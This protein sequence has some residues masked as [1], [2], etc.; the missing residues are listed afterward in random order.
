MR[1]SLR[2]LS[3]VC[4]LPLTAC[5]S[6]EPEPEPVGDPPVAEFV[7]PTR[8][9]LPEFRVG[10]VGDGNA[11]SVAA[12]IRDGSFEWPSTGNDANGVTWF[13]LDT[14]ENGNIG[15]FSSSA[16]YAV[17]RL[18]DQPDI[19]DRM[20]A[21]SS[22]TSATYIGSTMQ[23]GYFYGDGRARIP[24]IPKEDNSLVVLRARR[25]RDVVGQLYSTTDELWMNTGDL[26]AP[27][28]IVGETGEHW[29][30]VPV[31]NL[32]RRYLPGIRCDV[33]DN[34]FFEASSTTFPSLGPAT[35]T[36]L[37][38]LLRPKTAPADTETPYTA[39]LRVVA[40]GLDFSYERDVDI[41]V[42][43]PTTG[44]WV[45]FKT[46]V[47]G[48]IQRYGVLRPS[49]YDPTRTDYALVLS[50]HGAGVQ[51]RGQA[52]AYSAK[53]WAF[54]IAP[55]NRHEFGFDWEEW[56]RFN[57][58]AAM[59]DAASLFATD[60]TKQYLTGHSMGGHGTWHVGVTTPGR[61]ATV[62]PSAGWESFYTYSSG[63]GSSPPGGAIGRA[64]A[65]SVTLDYIDNL[66][67]RGAFV[68]HGT[69]DDNV[70]WS[71]GQNMYDAVSEVTDDAHFH[72][73]EGAGHWWDA[74]GDEPG[75]DCVDWEPMFEWMD[76]HE[77]D[78]FETDFVFRSPSP[79]YQ[80]V[81]SFVT[82]SSAESMYSDV[83]V[84]SF[85]ADDDSLTILTDNVRTL[86]LDGDALTDLGITEV[87]IDGGLVTVVPGPITNGPS[88]G[89]QKDVYG[90][91]NQVYRAPFC[92]VYAEGGLWAEYTSFLTT[93]WATLGN[94][95]ACAVP[96][97]AL[98][99]ELR[100][101]YQLIYVGID[102]DEL[103]EP[104]GFNWNGDEIDIGPVD[105]DSSA[106]VMVFDDGGK[107]G[108][109]LTATDDAQ[110]ALFNA[111]PFSSRSGMPDWT[112][113]SETGIRNSGMF[114]PDW[115]YVP[116]Q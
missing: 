45:T 115:E 32:V 27:D 25:G 113:W 15:A 85:L 60:P 50:L 10:V 68:I 92:F 105:Y 83:E 73:Q 112:I 57:A 100:A 34:E 93:Y 90:P 28:L 111:V 107:L 78:P 104:S 65:H 101:D 39:T 75:A 7:E 49:D 89:K 81:H 21:R 67:Q 86:I 80:S 54:I 66:A 36:Q 5:P 71:E 109:V 51:G 88:D 12:A 14:D 29:L 87:T 37:G 97:D 64:R 96:W 47:D 22:G 63:A 58:L 11:D 20:F 69:A 46:P 56:G 42:S 77:R 26:T 4:V 1:A 43:E 17:A 91:Y 98:T 108:G 33:I 95:R 40:P 41:A 48:S 61:F 106:L 6:P 8:I 53:D 99:D 82:V 55:T 35:V 52:R 94:G 23:P 16:T 102:E 62:A 72:W 38:F 79:G 44:H 31:L 76:E 30:G 9:D 70:P 114:T 3:V 18:E 13:D 59:D 74:D 2:L 103:G 84:E 116:G 19:G 110:W 24:L